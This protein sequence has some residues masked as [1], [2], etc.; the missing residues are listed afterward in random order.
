MKWYTLY[1]IRGN[2]RNMDKFAVYNAFSYMHSPGDLVVPH[3][4][5]CYELNL[6]ENGSGEITCGKEG[7]HYEGQ[8]IHL[9]APGD[10][11]CDSTDTRSTV[12]CCLFYP[13]DKFG[14]PSLLMRLNEKNKQTMTFLRDKFALLTELFAFNKAK[15]KD[16]ADE[17]FAQIYLA[18]G[19][20][21]SLEHA[22]KKDYME[23]VVANAKKYIQNNFNKQIDFTILSES[24]GY[25]YDRFRHI[26]KQIEAVSLKQYQDKIRLVYAKDQLAKTQL[27]VKEIAAKTGFNSD[28]R[29]FIW[30]RDAVGITPLKYRKTVRDETPGVVLNVRNK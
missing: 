24:I 12:F 20:L 5:E 25:S 26:F 14:P 13:D 29:F 19:N 10:V 18:L 6:Y 17:L 23:E 22:D 28:V 1:Q 7:F 30:F 8:V 16:A 15:D 11:H 2:R 21:V 4:H 9:V 3:K 27:S